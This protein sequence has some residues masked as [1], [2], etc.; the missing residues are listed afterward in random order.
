M[1]SS[2]RVSSSQQLQIQSRFSS[3]V[4]LLTLHLR[5]YSNSKNISSHCCH[6]F[7]IFFAL[8]AQISPPARVIIQT[9]W[10]RDAKRTCTTETHCTR[11]WYC[12]GITFSLSSSELAPP[13]YSDAPA[14]IDRASVKRAR[15]AKSTHGRARL[16]HSMHTFHRNV[17]FLPVMVVTHSLLLRGLSNPICFRC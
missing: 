14:T 12:C 2:V 15:T 5:K 13:S 9:R 3:S 16:C 6:Q 8:G 4:N 1:C 7:H 17:I 10:V 11:Y